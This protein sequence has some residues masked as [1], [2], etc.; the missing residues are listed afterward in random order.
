MFERVLKQF[1]ERIRAGSFVVTLHAAEELEDEGLS[2]YDVEA[3]ILSGKIT[4][5][6]K[7]VATGEWK[8]LVSG[9]TLSH[10]KVVVVVKLSPTDKL[11]IITIYGETSE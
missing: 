6:Q 11:I 3:A 8:Y 5:R 7:D 2:V 10:E 4:H 1:R 9:H